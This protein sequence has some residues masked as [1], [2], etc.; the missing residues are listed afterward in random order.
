MTAS[1]IKMAL[2]KET[3]WMAS[4]AI[5]QGCE[6]ARRTKEESL[7]QEQ[8]EKNGEPFNFSQKHAHYEGVSIA[9]E[10]LWR[11]FAGYSAAVQSAIC[12]VAKKTDCTTDL[13][14]YFD[15]F[16]EAYETEY[17]VVTL[18]IFESIY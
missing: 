14:T 15:K 7:K 12:K 4:E 1:E 18:R 13:E 5:K 9:A 17:G 16:I 8:L 2:S 6:A 3:V 10:I 11:L